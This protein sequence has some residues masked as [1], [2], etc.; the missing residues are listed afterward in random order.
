[1]E[2]NK[3]YNISHLTLNYV[4]GMLFIRDGWWKR[5]KSAIYKHQRGISIS[6]VY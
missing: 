3:S 6:L 4:T 5:V 1:M 2:N